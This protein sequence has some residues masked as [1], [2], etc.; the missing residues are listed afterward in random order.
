MSCQPWASSFMYLW[1][2]K[3]GSGPGIPA[4]HP[5]S[6]QNH[7]DTVKQPKGTSCQAQH[8]WRFFDRCCISMWVIW[9]NGLQKSLEAVIIQTQSM[10]R[11]MKSCT[12]QCNMHKKIKICNFQLNISWTK[13]THSVLILSLYQWKLSYLRDKTFDKAAYLNIPSPS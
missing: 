4:Q 3:S 10:H 11:N 2:S 9:L 5:V 7:H 6:N 1:L 12:L 13:L 8:R